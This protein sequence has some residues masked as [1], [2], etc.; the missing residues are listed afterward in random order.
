MD[1]VIIQDIGLANKLLN[2]FPGLEVHASTQMSVHN[3]S[4]SLFLK[5]LGFKR[6]VLAR[7]LS[8]EEVKDISSVIETEVFIHGALCVCYSG[9]CLIVV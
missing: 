8:I 5:D 2:R 7:E 1:G 3:R 6:I 9:Q 4:T